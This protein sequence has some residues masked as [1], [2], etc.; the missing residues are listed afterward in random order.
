M[1]E[2]RYSYLKDSFVIIEPKRAKRPIYGKKEIIDYKESPFVY[3]KEKN[4]PKEVFS[5]REYGKEN[6]PGW[7]VRVIPNLYPALDKNRKFEEEDI[8][9]EFK[10]ENFGY[11]EI[12]IEN[13]NP[14]KRF[15][16]FSEEDVK[17]ILI[18]YQNRV[19]NIYKDIKIEYI[20][21]FKNSKK[22]AGASI[23]HEHSQ[24]I[25][26]PFIPK[27]IKTELNQLKRY[28]KEKKNCF[29]CDEIRCEIEEDK[30]VIY[31]NEKFLIYTPFSSYLPYLLRIVPTSHTTFL[32]CKDLD[33]LAKVFLKS[34]KSL[35][36]LL[37]YPAYNYIFKIEP[38]S[39]KDFHFY[40]DIFPRIN[41]FGGYELESGEFINSI[42]PEVAAKC[43]KETYENI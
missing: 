31:K 41:E 37:N 39:I 26:T 2:I 28:L 8:C 30:R 17:N 36:K 1:G 18:A 42:Y 12:V 19:E 6:E 14:D 35:V 13:P 3:G 20:N 27:N 34:V 5:I 11:H 10:Y 15:F 21:I 16:E 24:I 40:I 4:T 23:L 7:L 43:L 9:L 22:E 25:A 29:L 33:N 38:K 32:E